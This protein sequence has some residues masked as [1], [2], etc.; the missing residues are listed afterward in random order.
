MTTQSGADKREVIFINEAAARDYATLPRS[1][2][3]AAD[4]RMT[5]VQNGGR[6]P[7]KQAKDL[8]VG[9][10]SGISEIRIPYDADTFRVYY[11]AAY[12]EVVYVLDA[13]MK[14]SPR[15]DE[16]PQPQVRR[17]VER[18]KVAETHYSTNK[19]A[20]QSRYAARAGNRAKME[21]KKATTPGSNRNPHEDG[22]S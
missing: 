3:E 22:P 1:V 11:V 19:A 4:G 5:V 17:L 21:A 7:S 13:G 9:K 2:K 20:L 14:K 10:L 15:E 8:T 16:I 12:R 18:K 6:L